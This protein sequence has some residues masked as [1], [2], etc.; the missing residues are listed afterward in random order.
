MVHLGG[1]NL[2][3]EELTSQVVVAFEVG[4]HIVVCPTVIVVAEPFLYQCSGIV[5]GRGIGV[6]PTAKHML[7][8]PDK[9]LAYI[10]VVEP[11]NG[12]VV[13]AEEGFG[14]DRPIDKHIIVRK[15]EML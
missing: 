8:E 14:S 2:R 3:A 1:I 10:E 9:I 15:D 7:L 12:E 13:F 11:Y 6:E 4:I 5:D